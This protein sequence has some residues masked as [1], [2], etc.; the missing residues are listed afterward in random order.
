MEINNV[1]YYRI[2]VQKKSYHLL[3]HELAC[4]KLMENE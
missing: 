2:T 1:K 3:F 4:I